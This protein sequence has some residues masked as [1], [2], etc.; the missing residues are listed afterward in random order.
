MSI[1]KLIWLLLCL[2][3][4][5]FSA[6][7]E[8]TKQASY[9]QAI[10]EQADEAY[11]ERQDSIM[12]DE[13]YDALRLRYDDLGALYPELLDSDGVGFAVAEEPIAHIHPVLSLKKAY[14]DDEVLSFVTAC[15]TN[16]RFCVEPKIDGLTLVLYYQNGVLVQ[17][18]TRGDGKAGHDVTAAVL[19]SGAVPNRVK[20][21]PPS[22]RA[23]GE[24]YLPSEAFEALNERRER[25]GLSRLKS[26]RST[27]AGSLRLSDYAEVARRGLQLQVFE[28][29]DGNRRPDC[30]TD[31]LEK[32]RAFGLPTVDSKRVSA[33]ELLGC[34]AQ[35][36]GARAGLPFDTDGVVIKVDSFERFLA[37]GATA[38]YPR[39]A[40]A[41]KYKSQ[42]VVTQLQRVEWSQGPSGKWTP[43]AHF[44]PVEMEGATV[45][46]ATLHNLNHIRAMD[47]RIGDWIQV[48]RAGGAVPEIVGVSLEKRSGSETP[49]P[50]PEH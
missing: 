43:V 7:D 9:L 17:A 23:R 24:L 3:V 13:A 29:I 18:L 8:V 48:I 19:A 45:Q 20:E 22:L 16:E 25:E 27:A 50:G 46:S 42:P 41:R 2:P 14:S 34:V 36:N 49:V 44:T 1:K 15:G 11:F 33:A 6:P 32:L 35:L 4:F 12:G 31:A 10:L 38:R 26:T 47:L 30:H 28:W 39:G 40:M 21:A 5:C 37:L